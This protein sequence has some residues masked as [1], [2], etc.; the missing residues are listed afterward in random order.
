M[1]SVLSLPSSIDGVC[2]R[3][4]INVVEVLN[5]MPSIGGKDPNTLEA[6]SGVSWV[7]S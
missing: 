2:F 6:G 3:F 1:R 5:L 4:L 7:P